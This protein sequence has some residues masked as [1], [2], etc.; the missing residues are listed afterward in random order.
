[1]INAMQSGLDKFIERGENT[2]SAK[3]TLGIMAKAPVT[4]FI[5]N[6]HGIHPWE[7][8]SVD[9]NFSNLVNLQSIGAAIQNMCL[10]AM[11]LGLGTLWIADVLYAYE[12]LCEFLDMDCQMVAALS[13]GYPDEAPG[14]RRRKPVDEVTKWL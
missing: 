3:W 2:G 5:F 10:A 14:P 8:H 12:E 6:Q 9:Q 1:M 13:I 7:Q 11:D 4:L